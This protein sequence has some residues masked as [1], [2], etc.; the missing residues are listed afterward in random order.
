VPYRGAG[1]ALIDVISGQIPMIVPAMTGQV[2]E[3]IIARIAQATRTALADRD[4]QQMLIESRFEPDLD[5]NP[6]KFRRA[7]ESDI[8]RWTPVVNA[9]GLKLD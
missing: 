9:I 1:P 4:Y 6:E 5:S 8:A 3:F 7:L 2:L